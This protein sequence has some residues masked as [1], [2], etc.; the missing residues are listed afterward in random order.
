[1]QAIGKIALLMGLAT[2]VCGLSGCRATAPLHVWNPPLLAPAVGGKIAI[3]PITNNAAIERNDPIAGPLR[4]AMLRLQP[5][6]DGRSVVAVDARTLQGDGSIR[7]VNALEGDSSELALISLARHAD[8]DFV[9]SGEVIT[10][11]Q[12]NRHIRDEKLIASLHPGL[13][14]TLASAAENSAADIQADMGQSVILVSWSL[15]DVRR[16][17]PLS[18]Q[19]VV[20]PG[21]PRSPSSQ[22]LDAAAT[23]AWELLTPHVIRSQAELAAPRLVRG[24]QAV[25]QGNT[26]AAAGDWMQ[27]EQIWQRV[28]EKQPKNHAALHNL[29][30]AAVARQEYGEARQRIAAALTIRG[31]D[32]NRSTAVWIEQSQRN[33]HQ[34]FGLD[35]PVEGWAATRR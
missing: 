13:D 1:M 18:G 17:Q 3:A 31:N 27:A 11:P 6:D 12:R 21:N 30:V 16:G 28:L 23:A 4:E 34:A 29:A 22:D 5:R 14:P 19:P 9:L 10:Q 25:R 20:T 2:V 8:V 33:Y 32:L 15:F 24:S 7:L 35:D 26:A